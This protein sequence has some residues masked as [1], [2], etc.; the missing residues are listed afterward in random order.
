MVSDHKKWSWLVAAFFI[1]TGFCI[2]GSSLHYSLLKYDDQLY[3]FHRNVQAELSLRSIC[4]ALSTFEYFYHPV[5]WISLSI[6]RFI[7]YGNPAQFH[8]TNC[9]VHC[10][11][12]FVAW[13]FGL[14]L[15]NGD[16]FAALFGSFC[17]LVHPLCAESVV[18]ISE[19][20]GLLSGLFGLTS[21][22]LYIRSPSINRDPDKWHVCPERRI[23]DNKISCGRDKFISRCPINNFHI[24]SFILYLI[25]ILSKPDILA[26]PIVLLL[27][28]LLNGVHERR[29]WLGVTFRLVPFFLTSLVL[30]FINTIVATNGSALEIKSSNFLQ[31]FILFS[32]KY[33]LYLEGVLTLKSIVPFTEVVAI[34]N[35]EI[36]AWAAGICL[37][38]IWS[39][40]RMNRSELKVVGFCIGWFII[41]LS[42][43]VIPAQIGMQAVGARYVRLP[44]LGL[45]LVI[46]YAVSV[47]ASSNL[48][49][50]VAVSFTIAWACLS[51]TNSIAEV[52]VWSDDHSLFLSAAQRNPSS[53]KVWVNL[54]IELELAGNLDLARYCYSL[55]LKS[56]STEEK[57]TKRLKVI[58]PR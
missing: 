34:N 46:G 28:E 4:A 23:C 55:A 20:K 50:C 19:R 36:L 21:V 7:S 6:D 12:A 53:A 57:A 58:G 9:I 38:T 44:M 10:L 40:L 14:V 31:W 15:F 11:T 42:V 1:I 13:R 35:F 3:V 18:W 16:K 8:F 5:T 52:R 22:Y 37:L 54:G 17:F 27:W 33:C 47:F 25:G 45:L 30:G 48:R 29:H 56:D 39:I 41:L 24:L 43:A 49:L 26:I 2:Y 51:V 32:K